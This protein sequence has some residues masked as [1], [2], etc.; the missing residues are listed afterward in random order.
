MGCVAGLGWWWLWGRGLLVLVARCWLVR[1]LMTM[2][3]WLGLLG[4]LMVTPLGWLALRV[5]VVMGCWPGWFRLLRLR[6][7]VRAG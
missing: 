7:V 1:W 4:L 2:V 6:L 5:G 3:G